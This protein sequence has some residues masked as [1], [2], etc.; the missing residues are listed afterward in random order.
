MLRV[1]LWP[2][3]LYR[4]V[5]YLIFTTHSI[6]LDEL[7]SRSPADDGLLRALEADETAH[8]QTEVEKLFKL[9]ISASDASKLTYAYRIWKRFHAKE[10]A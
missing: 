10:T 9:D 8:I 6:H 7:V 1:D 4:W 5:Q 2:I 3:S